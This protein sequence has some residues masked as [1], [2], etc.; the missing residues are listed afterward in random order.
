LRARAFDG[1]DGCMSGSLGLW[2]LAGSRCEP[3][4]FLHWMVRGSGNLAAFMVTICDHE[5]RAT[6]SVCPEILM[7]E[8]GATVLRILM[9]L[10]VL[11]FAFIVA[12]ITAVTR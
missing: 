8:L 7:L 4:N 9:K 3:P 11:F 10:T 2:R 5:A 1:L 6:R 12:L